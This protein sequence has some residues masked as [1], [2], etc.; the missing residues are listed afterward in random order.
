MPALK[1]QVH[2]ERMPALDLDGVLQIFSNAAE[3]A[4]AELTVR[5]GE[6]D[7]P[8][9]NY[10]FLTGDLVRLWEVLQSQVFLDDVLGP[11]L[12]H[13]AIATCQGSRGWDN[14]LLL[15]HYD[16]SLQ[17]DTLGG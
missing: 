6:D 17:L 11:Q 14:Y 4:D 2:P 5:E 16:Q 1:I 13:A 7:G 3:M 8:Y 12:A 9:I 10:D 15:H